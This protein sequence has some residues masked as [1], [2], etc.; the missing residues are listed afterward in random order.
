MFVVLSLYAAILPYFRLFLV[1]F[2]LSQEC[3]LFGPVVFVPSSAGGQTTAWNFC[4]AGC[5]LI[6]QLVTWA[7]RLY[8]WECSTRFPQTLCQLL[9]EE[10]LYR[11]CFHQPTGKFHSRMA[12]QLP[13]LETE[14]ELRTLCCYKHLC[15]YVFE[16]AS[17]LLRI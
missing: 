13:C 15:C 2:L 3:R 17:V 7:W 8:R 4:L 16:S 14:R 9:V 6:V 5:S 12:L 10:H 1:S 11:P